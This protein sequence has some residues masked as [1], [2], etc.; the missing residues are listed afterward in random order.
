MPG[1]TEID[2]IIEHAMYTP[3]AHNAQ[4]WR[5]HVIIDKRKKRELADAMAARFR[6]DLTEDKVP[7]K[8]ISK[9]TERSLQLFS[10]APVIIIACINMSDM[11][12]YPDASRQQAEVTMAT[13][14]LAACIQNLL[15]AARAVNLSGCWYCAPL[16]CPDVVKTALRLP[17]NHTPQALITIGYPAETPPVPARM[18]LDEIRFTI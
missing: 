6:S 2:R 14:S 10:E 18:Q 9:K 7:E 17:D 11:H 1:L 13:Q 4:P 15:L 12:R 3:S 8:T 5:F 16:F